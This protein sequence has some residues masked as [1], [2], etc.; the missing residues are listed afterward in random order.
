MPRDLQVQVGWRVAHAWSTYSA[1]GREVAVS[2]A[3]AGTSLAG[4]RRIIRTRLDVHATQAAAIDEFVS[5]ACRCWPQQHMTKLAR[6][7]P[8]SQHHAVDAVK[9]IVAKV[10][11]DVEAM[12]GNPPPLVDAFDKLGMAAVVELANLWFESSTNRDAIRRACREARGA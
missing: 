1:C 3:P 2:A 10:R 5:A 7:Q 12:W 9:V 6:R 11:E 4:L 8:E